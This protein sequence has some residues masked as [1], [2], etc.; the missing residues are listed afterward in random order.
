MNRQ[1]TQTDRSGVIGAILL[2]ILIVF[3]LYGLIQGSLAMIR[4]ATSQTAK[5]DPT[6]IAALITGAGTVLGSVSIASYNARRAQE[7]AAEAGN[8]GKKI[9]IY[10]SFA[11]SLM[12]ARNSQAAREGKLHEADLEFVD[13]FVSQ[14]T[15]HGGPAVIKAYDALRR[16][17]QGASIQA[18]R[19]VYGR[20][21]NLLLAMRAELGISNKGLTTNE[22]LGPFIAG[23]EHEFGR[24]RGF[25]HSGGS[26]SS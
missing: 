12:E 3:A 16:S 17:G 24:R 9:E 2:I 5:A 4:W 25:F 20:L 6:I 10:N 26:G 7:R 8:R 23:G 11:M 13:E 22:L 15:I 18:G 1:N 21:G 19:E 14:I